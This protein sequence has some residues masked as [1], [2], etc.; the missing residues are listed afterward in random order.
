MTTTYPTGTLLVGKDHEWHELGTVDTEGFLEPTPIWG[1]PVVESDLIGRDEAYV[2]SPPTE[3]TYKL[4]L[5]NDEDAWSRDLF[6][7]QDA[8]NRSL[9]RTF[10]M[11]FD[12][13]VPCPRP[14]RLSRPW[15]PWLW[16]RYRRALRGWQIAAQAWDEGARTSKIRT[17]F[18]KVGLA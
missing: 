15:Q 9:S 11:L 3:R 5:H 12:Q 1:L 8:V 6:G 13:E 17:Y 14:T 2:F 16:L 4:E 7:M 18:P 10:A